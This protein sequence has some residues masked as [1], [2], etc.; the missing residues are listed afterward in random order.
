[1]SVS[2]T[3]KIPV[4]SDGDR[5]AITDVEKASLLARVFASVH[6]GNHLT[7]KHKQKKDKVLKENENVHN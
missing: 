4:I 3:S 5:V 2:I 7:G 1:M 6:N